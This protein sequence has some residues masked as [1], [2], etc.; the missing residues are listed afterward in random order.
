MCVVDL[1]AG[2]LLYCWRRVLLRLELA[3]QIGI[4]QCGIIVSWS[5]ERSSIKGLLVMKKASYYYSLNNNFAATSSLLTV[6]VSMV[7][8]NVTV[9]AYSCPYRRGLTPLLWNRKTHVSAGKPNKCVCICTDVQL[10]DQTAVVSGRSLG[11]TQLVP[12][13]GVMGSVLCF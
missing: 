10:C 7:C 1:R 5:V 2:F 3:L 12:W 4:I 8:T 9:G 13:D 6:Q 11:F